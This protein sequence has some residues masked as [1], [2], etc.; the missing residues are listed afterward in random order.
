MTDN[1]NEQ[2]E[3]FRNSSQSTWGRDVWHAGIQ[4]ASEL[5]ATKSLSFTLEILFN[6]KRDTKFFLAFSNIKKI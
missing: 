4:W 6:D 3:H 1:L 5:L 2:R